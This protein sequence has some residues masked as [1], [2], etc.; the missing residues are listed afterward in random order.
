VGKKP[1]TLITGRKESEAVENLTRRDNFEDDKKNIEINY[2][3][4]GC[5]CVNSSQSI[6]DRIQWI[7]L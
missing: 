3:Q 4:T 1:G 7:V 2:R 5:E 6:Q